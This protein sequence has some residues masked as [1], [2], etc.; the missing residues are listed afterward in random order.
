MQLSSVRPRGRI[1]QGCTVNATL[2]LEYLHSRRL[3]TLADLRET[4]A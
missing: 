1:E 2:V 4:S 3:F